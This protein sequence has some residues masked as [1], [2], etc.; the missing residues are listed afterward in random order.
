V[1]GGNVGGEAGPVPAEP[2]PPGLTRAIEG[3]CPAFSVLIEGKKTGAGAAGAA[4]PVP[5]A[6]PPREPLALRVVPKT[7]NLEGFCPAERGEKWVRACP[8]WWFIL[9]PV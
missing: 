6:F 7:K 4:F 2:Q 9:M 5:L 8:I 3:S 1:F